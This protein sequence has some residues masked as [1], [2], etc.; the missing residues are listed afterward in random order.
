MK[1]NDN[2]R[3]T[4]SEAPTAVASISEIH[5]TPM[6]VHGLIMAMDAQADQIGPRGMGLFAC[7]ET[8]LPLARKLM[9]DIGRVMDCG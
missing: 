3:R 8:A 2:Q 5:A 4:K 9:A 1:H 6:T 7:I